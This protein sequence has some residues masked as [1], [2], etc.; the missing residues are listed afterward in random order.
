[1]LSYGCGAAAV[2]SRSCHSVGGV[3]GLDFLLKSLAFR[4]SMDLDLMRDF[5]GGS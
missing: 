1:M 5:G 3:R 4:N 2:P